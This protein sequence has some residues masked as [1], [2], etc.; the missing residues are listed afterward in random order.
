[1]KHLLFIYAIITCIIFQSCNIIN[2]AEPIPAYIKIDTNYL[3]S[4]YN[5]QG[6]SSH[7]ITDAWIYIDNQLEGG[8]GMPTNFPVLNSDGQKLVN[9]RPGIELNGLSAIHVIY[10]FYQ[11]YDTLVNLVPGETVKITP[12]LVYIAGAIFPWIEDFDDGSFSMVKVANADTI[13]YATSVNAF[14]GPQ[15]GIFYLDTLRRRIEY[16]TYDKYTLPKNKINVLE[17]NYFSENTMEV[18]VKKIAADGSS[19]KIP[20]IYLKPSFQWKKIYLDVSPTVN[21]STTTPSGYKVYFAS[22]IDQGLSSSKVM[23]DNFKIVHN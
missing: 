19:T 12:R 8:Y 7:N 1:M 4:D 23:I 2:P 16:E 18:G 11:T 17:L 15:S 10:P 6:S 13:L 22:T 3:T 14:E 20:I 21:I 9:V 5:I